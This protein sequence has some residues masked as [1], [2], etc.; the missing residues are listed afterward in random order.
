MIHVAIID[1]E[2]LARQGVRLRLNT[3]HDITIVA[4]YGDGSSALSGIT[5]LQP[6]LVFID[7]QMPDRSGL[8]VL[9]AL[10]IAARPIAILLTAYDHFAVRAFELQALDYLLKP[11]DDERFD[12][13]L[14]RARQL[15]QWRKTAETVVATATYRTRLNVRIGR[16]TTV[17]AVR[18]VNWI[19]ADGDYAS[20]HVG[21]RVYLL[22]ESLHQL[23][24]QLD[25]AQFIRIHRST[26]VR[27]DSIAEMQALSNR[28]AV[29]RLHDGSVLR[30]SRT[31]TLSL[32]AAL[33]RHRN[34]AAQ[35]S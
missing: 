8:D 21:E 9:A 13:A 15:L 5:A 18:E 1:D 7:V 6:D 32:H 23:A 30:A 24:Q 29:L 20:L 16:R 4:E 14:E 35:E 10:P 26:I 28:D 25:P 17:V 31:Y 34:I 22:R 11:I 33:N 12:E 27:L 2:P 19:E 3:H